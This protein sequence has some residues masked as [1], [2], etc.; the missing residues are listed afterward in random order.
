MSGIVRIDGVVRDY[1]WGRPGGI[2]AV[3]GQEP[4]GRPEAELWLGAHPA[5]PSRVLTG[6]PG[7]APWPDLAAWEH[8]TGDTLPF[9]M[10]LLAAG[11]PLSLQAHP[12]PE[13]ARAGF[14]RE[15]AAG[16][17]RDAPARSFRDPHAKPEVLLAVEDGFDA[18]CGFRPVAEVVDLL[19][20]LAAGVP[21]DGWS[22]W[23]SLLVAAGSPAAGAG[24]ALRWLLSGDEAVDRMV[25]ALSGAGPTGLPE[26]EDD[27]VR[28][29]AR[30]HPGDPGIAVALMLNRVTLAAGEA[31]W[32][33]A[34]N[35]HAYLCG[36]GVEVMGPSD[37]VLRGGLTGKHVDVP[38]LLDVLDVTPGPPPLLAPVDLGP[39][40]RA[41]RPSTQETGATVPWQLVEVT[42]PAEVAAG[43][44]AVALVLEGEFTL[45]S[46]RHGDPG[47]GLTLARGEA[48]FV[49]RPG[50]IT[51]EGSGALYL[52][53]T[54]V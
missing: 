26:A 22:R 10:K 5:A 14:A 34:G 41:Y 30:H 45:R 18:L 47:G 36:L 49:D 31:L 44:A 11:A 25:D 51:L 27:L 20:R 35:I 53:T 38:E 7:G 4:T 50:R 9:L 13:Q 1:A 43:S 52:A 15:E 23:R 21:T 40:V 46:G 48:G 19:D 17:P 24:A 39:G 29:L 2:S 42:G 16:I 6:H 37:N 3:R 32:L 54:V 28:L 12:G 8:A 33:P